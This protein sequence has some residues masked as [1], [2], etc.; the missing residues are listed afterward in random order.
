MTT[1]ADA[2]HADVAERTTGNV[3]AGA[4]PLCVD[5]DG[6]L[7]RTDTLVEGIVALVAS[8]RLVL[9]LLLLITKGR[10]AFKQRVG[11]LATLDPAL[12]PYHREFLAYLRAQHAHGRRIVLA[13]AADR[14]VARPIAA[15]LAIFDDVIASD[16]QLNLKG[17]AKARV[18]EE[19]FG[20]KGFVYAGNDR[21]DLAVWEAAHSAVIVNA[22][23]DVAAAARAIVAVEAA[24]DDREPSWRTL[25][26]AMRPHQW[27]KNLLIFV[28]IATAHAFDERTAWFGAVL[29]F[30]AFCTTASSIYLIN[31]LVDVAADRAH[32]KKRMRPFASGAASLPR[33]MALAIVLL[34]LG[35][36]VA[37][38]SHIAA[39]MAIYILAT[40]SY[41]LK[42]KELPLVD[43]FLLAGL[44]TIR[45]FGGGAATGHPVSLWLLG[46]SS[47]LFLSLALLK[48][49]EEVTAP[50]RAT[51]P[52]GTARRGYLASDGALLQSFG[53]ASTFASGL[54]LTLFVESEAKA[55]NYSAPGLLW[56]IVPLL[57]FWQC[58]LW[59]STS[60]GYMREDPIVYA[61]YDWVSWL[62]AAALVAILVAAKSASGPGLGSWAFPLIR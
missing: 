11:A 33:G 36:A 44:Y 37:W 28:P 25:L 46:F 51:A 52:Q 14:A 60:R 57:L 29:A 42:L 53:C 4:L 41:S 38:V 34:G 35:L 43:V 20:A 49:V 2:D 18:L 24:F 8:W 31:D 55:E 61:T 12:L 48:R 5:L 13:T 54:V 15:H 16:G 17:A 40:I 10:A 9:A 19:R 45:L 39:I 56:G 50:A 32:P 23:G 7:V 21:S 58:R 26:R 27:A 22:S 59:L 47:F 1:T 30:I 62:V 3:G 6:T